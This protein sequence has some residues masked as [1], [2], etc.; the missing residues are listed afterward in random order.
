[1]FQE[2]FI[3]DIV[4]V[5]GMMLVG[6]KCLLGRLEAQHRENMCYVGSLQS[7]FVVDTDNALQWTG[8]QRV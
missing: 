3:V 7:G 1:M 6:C 8:Q 4:H 2:V 5:Y